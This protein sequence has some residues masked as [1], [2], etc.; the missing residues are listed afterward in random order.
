MG[1]TEASKLEMISECVRF[2]CL[3]CSCDLNFEILDLDDA[4]ANLVGIS[5]DEK[6]SL[7]GTKMGDY[8]HP[9]DSIRVAKEILNNVEMSRRYDV[10]Y[11][12]KKPDDNYMWVR[13]IGKV[14]EVDQKK[15]VECIVIDIDK[16]EKLI[17]E[18]DVTYESVPGGV[19]FIVVSKDNF[20]IREGNKH[21]FELIG[22]V[23]EEY[24]GSSGKYTF[25]EDLPKLREHLVT[26]AARL[27]P[28]DYEFRT[29]RETDGAVCWYQII[30]NHYD[31][32]E[33]GQEYLC[34]LVDVSE[35]KRVQ[36][37][38]M[39][40]KEKYRL[41]MSSTADMMYEY[42]ML[43]DKLRLFDCNN[44]EEDTSICIENYMYMGYKKLLFGSDLIYWGDRR[45]IKNFIREGNTQNDSI[46]ILTRNNK[47]GKEY[48]ENYEFFVNKVY[49]KDNLLRVIGFV[50]KIGYK[51]VPVTTRQELQLIFDDH[52]S[53][54]FSFLLKIDVPSQ[55]FVPYFFENCRWEDYH[56]DSSYSAFLKWWT[57]NMVTPEKRKELLFFLSLEQ[58]LRILHSG[59][60]K[61]YRFCRTKG[62][63]NKY[64]HKICYFSFYN[65][66]VNTVILS[67][68]DVNAVRSEEAYQERANQ[69]ILNDVLYE[70][71][72]SVEGRKT[73][74]NFIV[75]EFNDPILTLK[76][77]LNAKTDES[78]IK[79]MSQITDYMGEMI[80]SIV[81]YNQ[82][83]MLHSRAEN[84][85]NLYSLCTQVCEEERKISIGLDISLREHIVLEP[86]QYYMIHKFRFKEILVNVIGNAIKYGTKGSQISLHV[87]EKEKEE[88]GCVI[89][90]VVED[91]GPAISNQFY[92]RLIDDEYEYDIKEKMIA[93]GSV[94]FSIS[95]ANRIT[96]LMGGTMTCSQGPFHN[97][98]VQIDI[99]VYYSAAGENLHW[100]KGSNADGN[101]KQVDMS[102]QGI[103]LLENQ[104]DSD[105]LIAPLLKVNG[106]NVYT[107]GTGEEAVNL[108]NTFDTGLIS[109]VLVDKQL[110]DMTCYEFAKKMRNECNNSMKKTPIIVML[111]GIQTDDMQI[112]LMSGINAT[113]NKP[114]N[115]PK[116]LL[117]I[118][119]LQMNQS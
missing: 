102:G 76:E 19:F 78:T 84:V 14:S 69:K 73:F 115:L 93:L 61:G 27:E 77:M 56:G 72:Q 9:S 30:G 12:L 106:A 34:V 82:L 2:G 13:E 104:E 113:I 40:E 24:L 105:K 44:K 17:K 95:L 91:E 59:E 29:R 111:D 21:Y 52:L 66:D 88:R 48:Y 8:I 96:S 41:A 103:L 83:E 22:A 63:D 112:S 114:I 32:L 58:M 49:E 118:E 90:V 109:A 47:S 1:I 20:Y 81:E 35:K 5:C 55:T 92:D 53:K 31:T 68:V 70:A 62:R 4:Y 110:V 50:K 26:Q 46:R 71:K 37:E 79:K 6:K 119:N 42:D 23:R 74:I 85:C 87:Q 10:K 51:T 57:E 117:I 116:L 99:P 80:G 11:R 98:I 7:I 75:R 45:K 15:V 65:S 28:I 25:P 33:D 43:Q 86:D 18:R 3:T 108:L 16:E 89:S 36:F 64:K 39:R 94:G 60:P 107:A 38:L 97:N 54:D 101:F 100:E 67:V